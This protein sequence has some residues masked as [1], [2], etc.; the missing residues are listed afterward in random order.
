[1]TDI[2]IRAAMFAGRITL[3][4]P[5][6]LN[7]MTYPMCLAIREALRKWRD[8][9]KIK[10]IL[11]DAE[12]D[13]AFCAGGDVADMYHC[14]ATKRA[15]FGQKFWRDEYR[16][17]AAI[18]DY[19]K[20]IVSFLQGFVMG[21]GVGVGCHGSHRIVGESSQIA[22]PECAIGLIPDVGGSYL[23]AKGIGRAGEY[24]GITG[25]RMNAADAILMGFADFFI[26]EANWKLVKSDLCQTG[27]LSAITMAAGAPSSPNNLSQLQNV[28]D[29]H[30][31]ATTLADIVDSL[32]NENSEFATGCLKSMHRNSPLSMACARAVIGMQRH[33]KNLREA[34][35]LEYRFVSRSLESADFLEGIRA[36]IIDK[37]NQPKWQHSSLRDVR[38]KD[39]E[40][41]LAPLRDDELTWPDSD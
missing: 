19:P 15:A 41:L 24:L 36:R 17:N 26:A 32:E 4:R 23:L 31:D 18:S 12:G 10:L 25:Q 38:D 3:Q 20:P 40:L 22:M 13:R 39:I 33:A 35:T 16:M 27:D 11:I 5:Q 6:A 34:L 30:F 28:I 14:E 1:M 7:A 37:D 8:D 9:P 2:H 21:G 29:Q